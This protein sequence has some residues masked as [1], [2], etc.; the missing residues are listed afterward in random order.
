MSAGPAYYWSG[1]APLLGE[2]TGDVLR[3]ELG[4]SDEELA[5]LRDEHVIGTVP[6]FG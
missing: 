4:V 1:P 3:G 2:H 5:R 6:V